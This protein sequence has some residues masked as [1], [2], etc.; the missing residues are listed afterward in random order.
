MRI[1]YVK[2]KKKINVQVMKICMGEMNTYNDVDKEKI[3]YRF[4]FNCARL[5]E[6]VFIYRNFPDTE[7]VIL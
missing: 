1:F 6:K 3:N 2:V 5:C 7:V 4:N